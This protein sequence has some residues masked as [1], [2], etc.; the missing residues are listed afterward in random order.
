LSDVKRGKVK[1]P[2][3][4]NGVTGGSSSY[5]NAGANDAGFKEDN[6][7]DNFKGFGKR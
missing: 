5:V 3:G 1:L 6:N 2:G 7:N 4:A